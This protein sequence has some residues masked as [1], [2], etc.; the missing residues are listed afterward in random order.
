MAAKWSKIE[1][2]LQNKRKD[3]IKKT[4][5]KQLEDVTSQLQ[6][7]SKLEQSDIV[8]LRNKKIELEKAVKKY[9]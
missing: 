7:K 1:K 2:L 4:V 6:D 9:E 8:D 5:E 3:R